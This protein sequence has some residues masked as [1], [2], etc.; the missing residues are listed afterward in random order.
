MWTLIFIAVALTI[1][2]AFSPVWA[3]L[4]VVGLLFLAF[5]NAVLRGLE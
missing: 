3:I 1:A 2:F 5:C 4:F